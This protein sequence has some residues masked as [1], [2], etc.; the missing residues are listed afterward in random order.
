MAGRELNSSVAGKLF[1]YAGHKHAGR[2]HERE[3]IAGKAGAGERPDYC[4]FHAGAGQPGIVAYRDFKLFRRPVQLFNQPYAETGSH[5]F[6]NFVGKVDGHIL[7]ALQRNSSDIASAFEF[8][9]FFA[10]HNIPPKN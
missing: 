7:Y 9:P 5:S 4:R 10:E 8:R 3:I 6:Y 1:V 2:A